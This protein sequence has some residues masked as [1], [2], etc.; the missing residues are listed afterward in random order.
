[1][2]NGDD[3]EFLFHLYDKLWENINEKESRVWTFLSVYG[4]V[5]GIALGSGTVKSLGLYGVFAVLLLTFWAVEIVLNA[6]WWSIRNRLMVGTIERRF[7]NA[8][9]GVVPPQYTQAFYSNDVLN[10]ISLLVLSLIAWLLYLKTVLGYLDSRG[11]QDVSTLAEIVL[12]YFTFV[13][14]SYSAVAREESTLREYYYTYEKLYVAPASPEAGQPGAAP[15]A[16]TEG[17]SAVPSIATVSGQD[18]P[19]LEQRE[20]NDRNRLRPR[21]ILALLTGVAA[22]PVY[23]VLF[24]ARSLASGLL[25]GAV[26]L[27]AVAAILGWRVSLDYYGPIEKAKV[28]QYRLKLGR[29]G[30][31]RIWWAATLFFLSCVALVCSGAG[32]LSWSPPSSSLR[33][34]NDLEQVKSGLATVQEKAERLDDRLTRRAGYIWPEEAG[35]RFLDASDPR[36]TRALQGIS[37]AEREGARV[38]GELALVREEIKRLEE[39]GKGKAKP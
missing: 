4:A 37:R 23:I 15:V 29:R 31:R 28:N 35:R 14:L 11:I 36:L 24:G 22:A 9:G 30:D 39:K 32:R 5:I 38:R 1:M 16:I 34:E 21:H 19:S 6:D 18:I 3:R 10:G 8:F 33:L 25:Y 7:P 12:L 26:A 20:Q 17:P 2:S 13:V 27:F